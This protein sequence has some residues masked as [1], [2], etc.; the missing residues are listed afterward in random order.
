M[1][2]QHATVKSHI[3]G[4]AEQLGPA[5]TL[6]LQFAEAWG[7]MSASWGVAPAIGRVHAYLMVRGVP[8]TERE[9]REALGLSHRAASL[10][11]QD[12]EAWGI[13]ERVSEPRRVGRRGPAGTAYVAVGDHWQWFTS[14]IAERKVREGDPIVEVIERTTA[15]AIEAAKEHPTDLELLRLRDW[16]T[17]FAGFV[18]LF[19]RSV[20]LIPKLEPRELERGMRLLGEIS[21]ETVL[22]LVHL[23]GGLPDDDVLE[24][25]EALSRL[26]PGAARRATKLMSGVVRTVAR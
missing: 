10:A 23:L 12:A 13:V 15:Q 26:S 24:L 18:R 4:E 25:V 1:T 2:R 22:R 8:L 17:A 5:E 6:R 16:L 7:H 20:G 14:V 11:L 21:D 3:S 9:V 19:D